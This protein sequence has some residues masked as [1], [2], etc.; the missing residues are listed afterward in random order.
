MKINKDV[1]ESLLENI[2]VLFDIKNGYS[3]NNPQSSIKNKH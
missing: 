2:E 1:S 3:T